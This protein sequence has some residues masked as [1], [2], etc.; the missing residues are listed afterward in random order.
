MSRG[1]LGLTA[2]KGDTVTFNLQMN[3]PNQNVLILSDGTI[4]CKRLVLDGTDVGDISLYKYPTAAIDQIHPTPYKISKPI[5]QLGSNP[6]PPILQ[7][8]PT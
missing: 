7:L 8:Q 5:N 1:V 3:D 4:Y 2:L 6:T